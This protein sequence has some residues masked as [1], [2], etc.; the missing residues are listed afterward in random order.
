MVSPAPYVITA[1]DG[2][3]YIPMSPRTVSFLNN[4]ASVESSTALNQ[5]MC[6]A[7]NFVPPPIHRHLKPRLRRGEGQHSTNW[8]MFWHW[9]SF[10]FYS[11]I[12]S[13]AGALDHFLLHVLIH[14]HTVNVI[15]IAL[16]ILHGDKKIQ[17]PFNTMIFTT[18]C[19]LKNGFI[20]SNNFACSWFTVRPPPLDL[21]GLSTITECPTH[22]PL[23][24][25]WWDKKPLFSHTVFSSSTAL[26]LLMMAK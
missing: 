11:R 12:H 13:V 10:D 18:L 16:L 25:S 1:A 3:G 23:S 19:C 4:D 15:Y 5:L 8:F 9:M 21:R 22:L 2:D 17:R 26:Y 20:H 24:D 7:G 14:S 6:Q